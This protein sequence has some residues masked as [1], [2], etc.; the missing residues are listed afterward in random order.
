M[1]RRDEAKLAALSWRIYLV[2]LCNA[3]PRGCATSLS[4]L[5]LLVAY[6]NAQGGGGKPLAIRDRGSLRARGYTVPPTPARINR[7]EPLF[8]NE[9]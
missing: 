1:H 8:Q 7:L 6:T 3:A 2:E 9:R 5:L 4:L